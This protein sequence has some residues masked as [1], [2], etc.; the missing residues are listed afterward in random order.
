LE[1]EKR[2]AVENLKPQLNLNYY[3]INQP[4][5]PD[6]EFSYAFTDN[7]KLGVDFSFPIFLRKERSKLALAKLKI[8]NTQWE[9]TLTERQIINN[10]EAIYNRL[11]NLR[12]I[13]A[14][15]AQMVGGYERLLEAELMNLEQGES[16]LFKL[17][18][19][20]EKL[21][22]AQSKWIKLLAENEKHKAELYWAAGT[23]LMAVD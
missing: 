18:L 15:Q 7:Y 9:R 8:A 6:G 3:A 20:L 14:A 11:T 1:T 2:L 4:V 17:N 13:L 19:Q 10:L 12:S 16:D 21:I 23:T 5:G 22:E